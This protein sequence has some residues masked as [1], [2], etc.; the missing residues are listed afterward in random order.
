MIGFGK[1]G[2]DS[3]RLL[4]KAFESFLRALA[5][6]GGIEN[7]SKISGIGGLASTLRDKEVIL[8]Q[9]KKLCDG[10]GVYRNAADHG[11]DMKTLKS[12][13]VED[14]TALGAVLL[15]LTAIRSVYSYVKNGDQII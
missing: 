13:R 15:S 1:N 11:S 8:D 12:W 7:V 2:E 9:H 3:I 6:V 10:V 4:G 14:D 5:S